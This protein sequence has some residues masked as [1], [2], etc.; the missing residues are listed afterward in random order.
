MGVFASFPLLT[1]SHSN[2]GEQSEGPTHLVMDLKS[3]DGAGQGRLE[4]KRKRPANVV[5]KECGEGF[6]NEPFSPLQQALEKIE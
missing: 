5:L 2:A 1:I 6:L 3:V 4:K